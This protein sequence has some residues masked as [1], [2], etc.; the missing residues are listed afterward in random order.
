MKI[1]II[2]KGNMGSGLA[3]LASQAGHTVLVGS[4]D[5]AQSPL[6]AIQEAELVILAVP[7]AA[8]LALAEDAAARHALAGKTVI[9]IT[10][11][12]AADYMSLTIGHST[13]AGEEIAKRL[14]GVK[15]V[16]AFNTLFA[17]VVSLRAAG[18][19]VAATVLV[20]GDDEDAKR[21]II[22]LA[23]SFGFESV[24]AGA[25]SNARYLEPITEQ[26]IHLAY[27]KGLGTKI[28]F[29]LVRIT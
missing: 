29:A 27:V 1:A 21:T 11:P 20:A 10:N 3:K 13:S 6:A 19:K 18:A 15:V 16:K 17:D 2:G 5:P 14:P 26:L 9:D 28:G 24:D 22:E 8:A 23:S 12:L 7:Y 25:L 4:R